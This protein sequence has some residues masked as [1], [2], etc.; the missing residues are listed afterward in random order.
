MYACIIHDHHKLRPELLETHVRLLPNTKH[1]S[2]KLLLKFFKKLK[3]ANCI[4]GPNPHLAIYS[5]LVSQSTDCSRLTYRVPLE[6]MIVFLRTPAHHL[7]VLSAERHFIKPNK[8]AILANHIEENQLVPSNVSLNIVSEE[9]SLHEV[10]PSVAVVQVEL[11]YVPHSAL[12]QIE[13][14]LFVDVPSQVS[15]VLRLSC[16]IIDTF[17]HKSN[18][19]KLFLPSNLEHEEL[20][21][22]EYITFVEA[23]LLHDI[24]KR[25]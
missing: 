8:P 15:S 24:K 12:V 21:V 20:L 25:F 13:L 6:Y 22:K 18:D 23:R 10:G 11:E 3:E 17:S 16:E 4:I 7:H 5:S 19:S 1:V 14:E 9:I 2:L